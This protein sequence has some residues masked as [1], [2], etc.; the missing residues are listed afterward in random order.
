MRGPQ[1]TVRLRKASTVQFAVACVSVSVLAWCLA[2][3]GDGSEQSEAANQSCDRPFDSKAWF[4]T[5]PGRDKQQLAKQLARCRYLIGKSK[6]QVARLI[7][8]PPR[9]EGTTTY[10]H[11]RRWTYELGENEL[12]PPDAVTLQV[13]FN[14]DG[15]V[16]R[17]EL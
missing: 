3:C 13:V 9:T 14:A 12:I 4:A 2:A 16:R 15:R 10:E 1:V 17:A 5:G 11:T 7:G 6:R 8:K